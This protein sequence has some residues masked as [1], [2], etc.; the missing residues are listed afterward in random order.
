MCGIAGFLR[1]QK[2]KF[3]SE[4]RR[5]ILS[6]MGSAIA[7]RGPDEQ[8]FYDDET[9]SFVFRR[10]SIIDVDGGQQPIWNEDRSIFVAVNGEI[11]NHREL[12]E[13]LETNHTFRT[14]SDSEIVLHLYEEYGEACFERLNGMFAAVLWDTKRKK[15]LL[16]RDPLGIKPLYYALLDDG[17]IFGSELKAL[18]MHPE[19]PRELAWND[20]EIIGVQ[21]KA[22]VS[23]YVEGVQFLGGGCY[24]AI[25]ADRPFTRENFW[26]IDD[27]FRHEPQSAGAD[28]YRDD[29]A[30][31]LEDAV[32]KQL[33]SDVPVGLFLSGGIDSSLIAAIAASE[34]H[35]LHCFTV[36]ERTTVL[37][38]D[39]QQAF[40]V[41]DQLGLPLYAAFFDV[42]ALAEQFTFEDFERQIAMIES[43]RFDPEWYF[44]N[45]LHKF[46][47]REVP[48]LKVMLLGQG[49][50]E[51]AGGYSR[52][53]GVDNASWNDY[54][55]SEVD[56]E[57]SFYS[58]QQHGVP[59]RFG[60]LLRGEYRNR[61]GGV[62]PH[63][64]HSKMR[65][66]TYQLQHFNLWHEDRSS[67]Y[68]SV[69]SRV[70]FL[71]HRIV[72]L[73]AS[74]PDCDHEQLFWDKSI[75]RSALKKWLPNYPQDKEKVPF[76]VTDRVSVID[77]FVVSVAR[78]LYPQ[79]R[80]D[81]LERGD[82]PFDSDEVEKIH[83]SIVEPSGTLHDNAWYLVEIMA[84]SVFER[85][86][87]QPARILEIVAHPSKTAIRR[88]GREEFDEIERRFLGEPAE[89]VGRTWRPDTCLRI[90]RGCRI[91]M[92]LGANDES[93]S[94]VLLREGNIANSIDVPSGHDWP[95]EFFERLSDLGEEYKDVRYWSQVIGVDIQT[96][97]NT[98]D[99]LV[100]LGYLEQAREPDKAK[101]AESNG[102]NKN[103]GAK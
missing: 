86:C 41:C 103:R 10:L 2:Q 48:D 18:L 97:V 39:V 74:I 40:K 70:P 11:Y 64:Y 85:L 29:Y 59:S 92:S 71:D 61:L 99:Q 52:R 35:D 84:I 33:M 20:L 65:L 54:L 81:F 95:L 82:C 68:E 67:S 30:H 101:T 47:K 69:E 13:P 58:T 96:L 93:V 15:L 57:L 26:R 80:R 56:P 46:A 88:I 32:R 25:S 60:T 50:D 8:T 49:A 89:P 83:Q 6:D 53:L 36:V 38:G 55:A 17:L 45:E 73:A 37:A 75:V 42:E 9:L 90:A 44:K 28:Q 100:N 78:K 31:L 21:Q 63:D 1:F 22:E 91:L 72:E 34:T 102:L 24:A 12:R 77:D 14:Q 23:T 76:F 3:D 27:H 51:F 5:R 19:C 62:R 16:A 87:R 66:L 4:Q 7:R 43:P 94:L 79:F 98:F